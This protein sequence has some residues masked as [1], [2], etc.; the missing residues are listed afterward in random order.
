MKGVGATTITNGQYL[1]Y[2]NDELVH[3]ELWNY[4]KD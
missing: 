4:Q 1:Q 3:R 2:S